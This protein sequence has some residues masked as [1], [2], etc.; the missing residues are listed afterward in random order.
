MAAEEAAKIFRENCKKNLRIASILTDMGKLVFVGVIIGGVFEEVAYPEYLFSI[1]IVG[2]IFLMW[3][4]TIYF[5]K[6]IKEQ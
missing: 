6:G 5:N 1:G 2:F 3:I 4:G